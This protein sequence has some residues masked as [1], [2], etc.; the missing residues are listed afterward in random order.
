M[1]AFV[2]SHFD[3]STLKIFQRIIATSSTW[4]STLFEAFEGH[5]SERCLYLCNCSRHFYEFFL[6]SRYKFF[7]FLNTDMI[8]YK[9]IFTFMYIG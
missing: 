1:V 8:F 7:F 6:R 9:I 3:P 2:F 5:L 4:E